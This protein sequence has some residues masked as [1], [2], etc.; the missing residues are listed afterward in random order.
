MVTAGQGSPAVTVIIPTH[1]HASTLDLAMA[2]VLSQSIETLELV[3]I[4]DGV[5]DDAREVIAAID[6]PRVRF[7]DEAKTASRAEL[8]R[9]RVLVDSDSD[10]VCYLGDDDVMLPDHVETMSSALQEV[11]FTHP[12]P[13]YI[14]PDG[15]L[16][17]HPTD[18]SDPLCRQW[19]LNPEHNAVSLTGVAHRL[20]AYRRLPNGWREAPPGR[21]SDHYMWEQWF[22][23][24]GFRYST[25]RRLTVLEIRISSASGGLQP[26]VGPRCCSGWNRR[27]T[28]ASRRGCTMRHSPPS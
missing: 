26:S 20:D 5:G 28:S 8:V 3:V 9:H 13:A 17:A 14:R 25:G 23:T 22:R 6:D 19:H 12:L 2:S 18:L 16:A 1:D 21:W 11:D 7:L 15:A 10:Y 27:T 4:G 24:D